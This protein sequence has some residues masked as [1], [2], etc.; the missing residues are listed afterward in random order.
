MRSGTAGCPLGPAVHYVNCLRH[1]HKRRAATKLGIQHPA[2]LHARREAFQEARNKGR[3][4]HAKVLLLLEACRKENAS[5]LVL[6]LRVQ[7]GC[8]ERQIWLGRCQLVNRLG[9][10]ALICAACTPLSAPQTMSPVSAISSLYDFKAISI[11]A[12]AVPHAHPALP[13]FLPQYHYQHPY[14]F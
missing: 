7:L 1:M 12:G 2:A 6:T 14:C 4:G 9:P 8:L 3:N 13:V 11:A 5:L 10:K